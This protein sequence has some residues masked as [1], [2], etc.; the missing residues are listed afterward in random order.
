MARAHDETR[1]GR[2][3]SGDHI[4]SHRITPH[5]RS[6]ALDVPVD[7]PDERVGAHIPDGAAHDPQA[8]AEHR[9]VPKVKAR[10]KEARHLGLKGEVVDGVDVDVAAN[11]RRRGVRSPVPVVVLGVEEE[12]RAHDGNAQRDDDKN[13]KDEEEKAVHVVHLVVP[14]GGEDE[15]CLDEDG[16]EGQQAAHDGDHDGTKVPLPLGNRAG[17]GLDPARVIRNPVPVPADDSAEQHE[18]ERDKRPHE[19]HHHHGAE[20]NGGEGVVADGN[21]V[22]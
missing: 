4:T 16:A 8:Q 2:A 22:E 1:G 10:L 13:Q 18:R 14:D 6:V 5:A 15:V 12:V 19:E 21:G 3:G 11:G 9:G 17:N 7:A 20:R